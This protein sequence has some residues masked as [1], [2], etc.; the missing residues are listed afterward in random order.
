MGER[1]A[2]D[3]LDAAPSAIRLGTRGYEM[4]SSSSAR[5]RSSEIELAAQAEDAHGGSAAVFLQVLVFLP[6]ERENAAAALA[7]APRFTAIGSSQSLYMYGAPNTKTTTSHHG[8]SGTGLAFAC[9]SS[10]RCL[11]CRAALSRVTAVQ[12]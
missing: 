8:T 7:A 4:W 10:S 5:G 1:A 3:V 12:R 2:L 11:W 6:I 9:L